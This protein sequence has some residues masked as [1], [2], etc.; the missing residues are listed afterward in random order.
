MALVAGA[1]LG[2]R[3]ALA[4]RPS[5]VP[6]PAGLG[7]TT[8][9]PAGDDAGAT[10]PSVAPPPPLRPVPAPR[11]D[12]APFSTFFDGTLRIRARQGGALGVATA[13][14]VG[15]GRW[16]VTNRHVVEGGRT[17]ELETWSGAAAGT[18]TVVA[19]GPPTTDLALLRLDQGSR[20]PLP[21]AASLPPPASVLTA[22]GY[23][24]ARQFTRTTGRLLDVTT[25][26]GMT[27][28]VTD[29]AAAPGSSGSPLLDE[30]GTVVGVIFGGS[31]NRTLAVPG[32]VVVDLLVGQG[33]SPG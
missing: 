8:V 15:D 14:A 2:D 6:P 25:I 30:E 17:I 21:V 16:L 20:P 1:V 11:P 19:L 12:T 26:G 7:A 33:V 28:L 5:P 13:F 27:V 24:E 9:V 31:E 10:V 32:A 18:A 3:L 22:G 4:D 23:L 29:V